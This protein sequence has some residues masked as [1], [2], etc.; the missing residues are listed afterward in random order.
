MKVTLNKGLKE[1][2]KLPVQMSEVRA[3]QV[4]ATP[5]ARGEMGLWRG[6]KEVKVADRVNEVEGSKK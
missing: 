2:K 6:A 5:G 1:M 3:C 4:E